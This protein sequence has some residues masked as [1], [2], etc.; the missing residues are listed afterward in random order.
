M[1]GLKIEQFSMTLYVYRPYGSKVTHG[2]QFSDIFKFC[3]YSLKPPK[4]KLEDQLAWNLFTF[5]A[6]NSFGLIN[7]VLW[8][9]FVCVDFGQIFFRKK[10]SH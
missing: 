10:V 3:F 4:K 7:F 8:F 9:C 2:N 5:N 1:G 6:F